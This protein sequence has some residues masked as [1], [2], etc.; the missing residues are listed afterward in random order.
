MVA[1]LGL[2]CL[3]LLAGTYG[4][5]EINI[6]LV[7]MIAYLCSPFKLLLL[8]FLSGLK[9]SVG[10]KTRKLRSNRFYPGNLLSL[11]G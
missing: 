9:L 2:M 1:S 5:G 4:N 8:Q 7:R 6:F 11:T 3:Y 10:L